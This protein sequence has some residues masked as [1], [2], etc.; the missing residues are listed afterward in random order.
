MPSC[1]VTWSVNSIALKP[2]SL[3]LGPSRSPVAEVARSSSGCCEPPAGAN[4]AFALVVLLVATDAFARLSRV[5]AII[6]CASTSTAT[7][8]PAS[9]STPADVGTSWYLTKPFSG[10]VPRSSMLRSGVCKH[11]VKPPFVF[12]LQRGRSGHLFEIVETHL[13]V[14]TYLHYIDSGSATR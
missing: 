9:A 10:S 11:H 14:T 3:P 12:G 1:S 7:P 8:L 13:D 6:C 2:S 5:S 4:E